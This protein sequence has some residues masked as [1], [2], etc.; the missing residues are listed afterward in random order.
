MHWQPL[1][2]PLEAVQATRAGTGMGLGTTNANALRSGGGGSGS[3][4]KL[5]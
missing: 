5:R 4:K 1:D 2:G 3:T